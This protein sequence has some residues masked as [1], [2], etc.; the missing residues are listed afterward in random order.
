MELSK[1][2]DIMRKE[3]FTQEE[4]EDTIAILAE[5]KGLNIMSAH[6]LLYDKKVN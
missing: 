4:S 3:Q 6:Y 1:A 2:A 5:T